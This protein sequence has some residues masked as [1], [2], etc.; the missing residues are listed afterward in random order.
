MGHVICRRSGEVSISRY[1]KRG[2]L[3]VLTGDGRRIRPILLVVARHA[4]DGRTLLV[5]GVPEATS[6]VQAMEAVVA[7][8]KQ[9][10]KRLAAKRR[11]PKGSLV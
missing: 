3:K 8:R 1:A 9:I 11:N 6:D 4:Y 7:F 5:P 2:T 10:Q